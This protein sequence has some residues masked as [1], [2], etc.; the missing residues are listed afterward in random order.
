MKKAND[1][2]L[3]KCKPALEEAE[4]AVGELS[5]ESITELKSFK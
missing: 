1:L 2:E 3:A 4:R 5:K